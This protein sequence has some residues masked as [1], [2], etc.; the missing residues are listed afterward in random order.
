[1][2]ASR[3]CISEISR[4]GA[5]N[6]AVQRSGETGWEDGEGE[7]AASG[8]GGLTGCDDDDA[9]SR[10]GTTSQVDRSTTG[11]TRKRIIWMGGLCP[12]RGF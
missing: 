3:A 6:R 8:S 9:C 7:G 11:G 1:M 2:Q 4:L 5:G 12:A 10:S